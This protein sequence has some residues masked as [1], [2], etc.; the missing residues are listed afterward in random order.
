MRILLIPPAE[1]TGSASWATAYRK[2]RDFVANLSPDEKVNLTAGV[3]L[4]NGCMGNIPP[5]PRVGFPG[6]CASDAENGLVCQIF[7]LSVQ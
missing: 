6:L 7:L 3:K 5:I 4:G 2:A 1:G